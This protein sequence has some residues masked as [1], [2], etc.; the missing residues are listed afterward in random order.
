M[1]A[2]A[3]FSSLAAQASIIFVN[4]KGDIGKTL[5]LQ[6]PVI[7]LLHR[8]AEM[9]QRVFGQ[10]SDL[11]LGEVGQRRLLQLKVVHGAISGI[12]APRRFGA[13]GT[14]VASSMVTPFEELG[15]NAAISENQWGTD[16]ELN[17]ELWRYLQFLHPDP[18]SDEP[19]ALDRPPANRSVKFMAMEK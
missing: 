5:N 6:R 7:E 16:K 2:N 4:N 15:D 19:D 9:G 10:T 12:T 17:K 11:A 13:K 14:G 3:A 1:M 18:V 8:V